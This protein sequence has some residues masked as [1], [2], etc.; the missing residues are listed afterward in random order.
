MRPVFSDSNSIVEAE[1][2][3]YPLKLFSSIAILVLLL[4]TVG[5][6]TSDPN[7]EAARAAASAKQ[8]KAKDAPSKQGATIGVGY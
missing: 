1:P 7:T 4:G 3:G 5:C 6:S 2:R 8:Q